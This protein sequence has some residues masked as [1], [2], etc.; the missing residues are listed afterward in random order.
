MKTNFKY[1][2][3]LLFML[4][5]VLPVFALFPGNCLKFEAGDY[6][7]GTGIPAS[8]SGGFTIE[9]WVNHS[10]LSPN[11]QRYFTVLG[12]TMVLRL[13]EG[14]LDFYIHTATGVQYRIRPETQLVVG[15]WYHVAGTYDGTTMKLYKNGGLVGSL[16]T[17]GGMYATG[18]TFNIGNSGEPMI[19][20]N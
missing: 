5:A 14:R 13:D 2:L 10:S 20:K 16:A 19:G 4:T 12:E 6:V 8:F 1:F 17:S 7:Q 15:Q 18:A 9:G 3:S 11:I